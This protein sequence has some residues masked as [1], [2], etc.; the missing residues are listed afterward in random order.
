[1]AFDLSILSMAKQL[2]NHAS[3]RQS[4][5]SENVA[6]A[7]TVGYRARDLKPFSEVYDGSSDAAGP[8]V[9]DRAAKQRATAFTATATR[10]G[11]VG[12][13]PLGGTNLVVRPPAYEPIPIARLGAESGNGNSVS[14][15]DQLSRGASAVAHHEMAMGILR[16]S[17]DILR[18]SIGR[19]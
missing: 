8:G 10:P 13:D 5:I 9:A 11:H 12:F 17:M 18:M 16:K 1:M 2:A 15:E 7:D 6:N 14:L 3:T 4:L 19:G